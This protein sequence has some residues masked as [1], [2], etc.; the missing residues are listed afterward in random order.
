MKFIMILVIILILIT[1]KKRLTAGHNVC[2]LAESEVRA[3]IGA[4]SGTW[5]G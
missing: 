4:F 5:Q 1:D 3:V 2:Q